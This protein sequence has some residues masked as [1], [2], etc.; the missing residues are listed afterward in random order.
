MPRQK[1]PSKLVKSKRYDFETPLDPFEGES[2]KGITAFI[3]S[4]LTLHSPTPALEAPDPE[5][6]TIPPNS[7]SES[8]TA[9]SQ[10]S[11]PSTLGSAVESSTEPQPTPQEHAYVHHRQLDRRESGVLSTPVLCVPDTLVSS[12]HRTSVLGTHDTDILS[13]PN[14]HVSGTR[15][16]N[17]MEALQAPAEGGPAPK[18]RDR[19][20]ELLGGDAN[21]ISSTLGKYISSIH[22]IEVSG[23]LDM[24]KAADQLTPGANELTA[25]RSSSRSSLAGSPPSS[26]EHRSDRQGRT[27]PGTRAQPILNTPAA[28]AGVPDIEHNPPKS[29]A[30][31][32]ADVEQGP[33]APFSAHLVPASPYAPTGASSTPNIERPGSLS[34]Q[35]SPSPSSNSGVL[36][37]QAAAECR[38]ELGAWTSAPPVAGISEAIEQAEFPPAERIIFV[39]IQFAMRGQDGLTKGE[40]RIYTFLWRIV[41]GSKEHSKTEFRVAGNTVEISLRKLA[42]KVGLGLANCA[43]HIPC[44]E[45]K[46]CI[47]RVR[48]SDHYHPAV[49]RVREFAEIIQWRREHGLTHFIQRGHLAA[50]VDPRTGVPITR[51]RGM[52]GTEY[53]GRVISSTLDMGSSSVPNTIKPSMPNL[54]ALTANSSTVAIPELRTHAVLNSSTQV[55]RETSLKEERAQLTS[56]SS[57]S[58]QLITGL[59]QILPTVDQ[60]AVL[61]LWHECQSRV[62]DCTPDEVLHFANV[63]AAILQTGKI[64][65]PVGFLITAVPKCFEGETFQHFR[66]EQERLKEEQRRREEEERRKQQAMDAEV[67]QYRR[68][69]EAQ[70]EAEQLLPTLSEAEQNNLYEQA[71]ADYAARRYTATG[72]VRDKILRR[73]VIE[74]L[75]KRIL[76]EA[77]RSSS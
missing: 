26:E 52:T 48:P 47:E 57:I 10:E 16:T 73:T 29:L 33:T 55:I 59:Q 1:S 30:G 44:L 38:P 41:F 22:D 18:D 58:E 4:S 77:E 53:R 21:L 12:K 66:Q 64:Q 40:E 37:T 23:T 8:N 60:P 6:R 3:E 50:F 76:A 62:P 15:D 5:A 27:I 35:S 42:Q 39:R 61:L 72:S 36:G 7:A 19:T 2:L 75:A 32:L 34:G 51:F 49:Y 11:I 56:S 17:S 68:E 63:K 13:D 69:E 9:R 24:D 46:G 28:A 45:E 71:R 25:F 31:L 67:E 65:N 20:V 43:W 70:G 14:T 74:T 54:E